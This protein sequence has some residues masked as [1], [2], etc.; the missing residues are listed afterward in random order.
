M[1]KPYGNSV[2]QMASQTSTS[3]PLEVVCRIRPI[4]KEEPCVVASSERYVKLIPPPGSVSRSGEALV[5][6]Y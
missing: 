6:S 1:F 4:E 2:F 3:P 5:S